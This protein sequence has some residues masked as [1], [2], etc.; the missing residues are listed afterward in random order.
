VFGGLAAFDFHPSRGVCYLRRPALEVARFVDRLRRQPGEFLGVFII[1]VVARH[2][3]CGK[4]P[5]RAIA[6]AAG[7]VF[8]VGHAH[9]LTS[10]KDLLR[11]IRHRSGGLLGR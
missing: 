6:H 3:R 5:R 9:K 8:T 10:L 7:V 1:A 4:Q 11:D 2:Q